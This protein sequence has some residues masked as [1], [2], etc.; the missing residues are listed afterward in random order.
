MAKTAFF[1]AILKFCTTNKIFEYLF[2]ILK[3]SRGRHQGKNKSLF[4]NGKK[5]ANQTSKILSYFSLKYFLSTLFCSNV[6]CQY[7]CV[8]YQYRYGVA[9]VPAFDFKNKK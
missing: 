9:S 2:N 8:V 4:L 1:K 5:I 6:I 3:H 7:T